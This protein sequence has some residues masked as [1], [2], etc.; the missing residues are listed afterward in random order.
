M[1]RRAKLTA[2]SATTPGKTLKKSRV[3]EESPQERQHTE[4]PRDS[5][6]VAKN[7]FNGEAPRLV[8]DLCVL[9]RCLGNKPA[10]AATWRR[11]TTFR[12]S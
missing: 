9:S 5:G 12:S 10:P 3:L 2:A 4:R 11:V 6:P 1:S 7:L 8:H